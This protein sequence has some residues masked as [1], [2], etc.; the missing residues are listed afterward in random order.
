MRS[1]IARIWLWWLLVMAL[2]VAVTWGLAM[3]EFPG[4]ASGS[5]TL[6]DLLGFFAHVGVWGTIK[7]LSVLFLPPIVLTYVEIR[8]RRRDR[9]L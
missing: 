1:R 4:G 7:I 5:P 8:K 2:L 9:G 3:V 6:A